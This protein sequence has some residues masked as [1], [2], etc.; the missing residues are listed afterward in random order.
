[1]VF[2]PKRTFFRLDEDKRERVIR[3]AIN[4]FRISGFENA[5]VGVIAKN[6][7]IAN[8]SIYQYFDD[9]RELFLYCVNWTVENFIREIDR[10]MP[11]AGMDLFEYLLTGLPNRI[12]Y[13][14]EEPELAMFAHDL[15][16]GKIDFPPGEVNA[17]R[18]SYGAH[19][20]KLIANGQKWGMLRDDMDEELFAVIITGV[21]REAEELVY[22]KALSAGFA[23]NEAQ[24]ADAG[25]QLRHI[26]E[27][28][29]NG[30]TRK[31]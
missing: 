24:I 25:R 18:E 23:M 19:I 6:A 27:I 7:S 17:V 1:M 30:L 13:W 15:S 2:M 31:E 21:V 20:P 28:L 22:K 5:K 8:G 16:D 11:L 4:E 12:L 3:A 14:K 10:Q 9:K 29:S 26:I